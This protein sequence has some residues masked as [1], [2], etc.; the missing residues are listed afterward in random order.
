MKALT[1][2][3][4]WASLIVIGAKPWEFRPRRYF[5]YIAPPKPGDHIALHSAMRPARLSE[6]ERLLADILMDHTPALIADLARPLLENLRSALKQGRAM[7]DRVK[8]L[9]PL[10]CVLG[11]AVIGRP[12]PAHE[13]FGVAQGQAP[14]DYNWAWPMGDIEQFNVPVPA[15]GMRDLRVA[16]IASA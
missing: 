5:A 4:P 9:A 16:A 6:V 1:V 12:Q 11:T 2:W 3:Q 10:G 14:E 8:A 13:I 7:A 15:R